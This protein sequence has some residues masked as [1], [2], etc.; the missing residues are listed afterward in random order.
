MNNYREEELRSL[1]RERGFVSLRED[2]WKNQR[3][4]LFSQRPSLT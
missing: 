2:T 4:F 3:L 1:F